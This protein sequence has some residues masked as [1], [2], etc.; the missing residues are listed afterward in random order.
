MSAKTKAAKKD[1]HDNTILILDDASFKR[2]ENSIINPPAPSE[3]LRQ[4]AQA[5]RPWKK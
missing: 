4:A 2:F 3:R 5:K 1:I